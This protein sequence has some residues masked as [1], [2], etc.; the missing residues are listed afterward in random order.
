MRFDED[1]GERRGYLPGVDSVCG[2]VPAIGTDGAGGRKGELERRR[3]MGKAGETINDEFS[4][5]SRLRRTVTG[6][7]R[8]HLDH[9]RRS[10]SDLRTRHRTS[11]TLYLIPQTLYLIPAGNL[12][13]PSRAAP[14][15]QQQPIPAYLHLVQSQQ[16]LPFNH[17]PGPHPDSARV[18]RRS[19]KSPTGSPSG[20]SPGRTR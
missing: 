18:K 7:S 20:G 17:Q 15:D 13:D 5:D 14:H 16:R 9:E 2:G 8:L 6:D 3:K 19:G 4:W 1:G 11:G 12:I 10:T